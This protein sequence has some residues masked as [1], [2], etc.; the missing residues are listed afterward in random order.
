MSSG[1]AGRG[2]VTMKTIQARLSA[3][4]TTFAVAVM[5]SV[6]GAQCIGVP[7][8]QKSGLSQPAIR[9]GLMRTGYQFER[10]ALDPVIVGMWHVK[11]TATAV[12]NGVPFGPGTEFD[13]GFQQWH[14]DGTEMLNSAKPP[15]SQSFCMGVWTQ[16]G[17][18]TFKLN[19]FA[20]SWGPDGTRTG[21]TSI[22]EEVTVSPNGQTFSGHV[23]V[24]DYAETDTP[25]GSSISFMD[26]IS[27]TITGTKVDVNTPATPIF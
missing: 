23:T 6:A 7:H 4:A 3:A 11:L 8:V 22:V 20:I 17:P 15:A 25:S 16:T 27:G 5:A 12:S 2:E 1:N 9:G 19:H 14:S 26:S 13:A 24:T 21:P 18:R 10:V